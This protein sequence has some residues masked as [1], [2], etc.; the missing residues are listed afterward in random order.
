MVASSLYYDLMWK[1]YA[2]FSSESKG[3]GLWCFNSISVLLVEE[4]G[5]NHW[6]VPQVI[7][8]LYHIMLYR[9]HL[10]VSRI[11]TH[12]VSGDKHWLHM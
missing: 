3:E 1:C 9:V 12:N 2:I 8:K 4:T 5:E 7:D 6:P 11:K 10:A